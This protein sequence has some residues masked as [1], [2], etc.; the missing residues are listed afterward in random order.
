MQGKIQSLE[1]IKHS[2]NHFHMEFLDANNMMTI[3]GGAPTF[4]FGAIGGGISLAYYG[5]LAG[6]Q[7]VNFYGNILKQSGRFT[8]GLALGLG[9]GYLRFGDRQR[10]HNAWVAERLR[11]RHPESLGLHHTEGSLWK[12]KGVNAPQEF[13]RWH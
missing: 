7:P 10:L 3:L 9:V 5:G 6:T 2:P 1:L 11:R 8:F 4:L 12:L 13:Y